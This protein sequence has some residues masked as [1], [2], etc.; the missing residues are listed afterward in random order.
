MSVLAILIL[1]SGASKTTPNFVNV[2]NDGSISLSPAAEQSL[3]NSSILIIATGSY[4]D[5]IMLTNNLLLGPR[6]NLSAPGFFQ[7]DNPTILNPA[8]F[9]FHPGTNLSTFCGNW[10]L[11]CRETHSSQKI[12]VGTLWNG[13]EVAAGISLAVAS[14]AT[15]SIYVTPRSQ[16]PLPE[17]ETLLPGTSPELLTAAKDVN[18]GLIV[19]VPQADL[20]GATNDSVPRDANEGRRAREAVYTASL[21]KKFGPDN[22]SA[23]FLLPDPGR[24][25]NAYREAMKDIAAF[26]ADLGGEADR[27][28]R[29]VAVALFEK[30]ARWVK[31]ADSTS[32]Q[33]GIPLQSFLVD[34]VYGWIGRTCDSLVAKYVASLE[35]ELSKCYLAFE[36]NSTK[37]ASEAGAN[38]T[39]EL[40]LFV[41]SLSPALRAVVSKERLDSESERMRGH[42]TEEVAA[43]V[44]VGR[45]KLERDFKA[46]CSRVSEEVI[47]AAKEELSWWQRWTPEL[48]AA[49][50]GRFSDAVRYKDLPTEM[51]RSVHPIYED[52]G[53]CTTRDIRFH[54]NSLG[55]FPGIVPWMLAVAAPVTLT[56]GVVLL[57]RFRNA[58]RP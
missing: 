5:T 27:L 28:P 4:Q 49:F 51:Q 37:T 29:G 16:S 25:P 35:R 39:R 44:M 55:S 53:H 45:W 36:I 11:G 19:V 23:V 31:A 2:A 33:N 15:V 52:W 40:R 8:P 42:L 6:D 30:A 56:A 9:P 7:V 26:I 12:V 14:I 41:E 1:H 21:H 43:L 34:W 10:E 54:L 22:R 50:L 57:K 20:P 38:A 3:E 18:G 48:E 13:G 17:W 58:R 47:T 46:N 24:W 32:L